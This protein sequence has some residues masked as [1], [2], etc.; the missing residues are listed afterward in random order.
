MGLFNLF[1]KKVE[2]TPPPQYDPWADEGYIN[3]DYV[4]T[5]F[6]KVS[7][8]GSTVGENNGSYPRYFSYSYGIKNP[9]KW[10][11][12]AID[13]GFLAK[14][15]E[16]HKKYY[17]TAKGLEY[18]EKY[19]YI[20]SLDK[21]TI[22]YEEFDKYK[23]E[24]PHLSPNDVIWGILTARQ[25]EGINTSNFTYT[26]SVLLS[27]AKFLENE[28]KYNQALFA[29]IRVLRFSTSGSVN[30][31]YTEDKKNISISEDI[32]AFIRKYKEH[33]EPQ[34]I[35]KCFSEYLPNDYVPK[36]NFEKLIND[37]IS[38]KEIVIKKYMK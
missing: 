21:Y 29:M 1:Q 38:E 8:K 11:Q 17:P 6:V 26:K 33:Y 14:K 30:K 19:N 36:P 18:L 34:M 2:T 20:F 37:I 9:V 32:I 24:H 13:N 31:H 7:E 4:A 27:M 23:A 28:G 10:H 25:M 5:V 22:S 35:E 15:S 12:W 3:T 16:Q